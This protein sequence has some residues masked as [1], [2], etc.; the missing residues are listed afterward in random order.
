[1]HPIFQALADKDA[2]RRGSK[3]HARASRA[4]SDSSALVLTASSSSS[5]LLRQQNDSKKG[6]EATRPKP[7]RIHAQ[8]HEQHRGRSESPATS[9]TGSNMQ[10]QHAS[11]D[12]L[13]AES[14]SLYA[15]RIQQQQQYVGHRQQQQQQHKQQHRYTSLMN[16][17]VYEHPSRSH[18][19]GGGGGKSK[20]SASQEED[21]TE[22]ERAN[23]SRTQSMSSGNKSAIKPSKKK[24][25]APKKPHPQQTNL[26]QQ[27][28]QKQNARDS[29]LVRHLGRMSPEEQVDKFLQSVEEVNAENDIRGAVKV[30][31]SG[32]GGGTAKEAPEGGRDRMFSKN[33]KMR[34]G[35][36]GIG[37][38]V[39]IGVAD[40]GGGGNQRW[41]S[42]D[43]LTYTAAA[44]SKEVAD[45]PTKKKSSL[46]H[47]LP[48][49][50]KPSLRQKQKKISS[51]SATVG[52]SG[53]EI[54]GPKSFASLSELDRLGLSGGQRES[55]SMEFEGGGGKG[56]AGRKR[57]QRGIA[58]G[59][60][61]EE[62]R[63]LSMSSMDLSRPEQQHHQNKHHHNHGSSKQ[64][65]QQQQQQIPPSPISTSSTSSVRTNVIYLGRVA[66][67]SGASNLASLQLPLKNLYLDFIRLSKSGRSPPPSSLEIGEEG[68]RVSYAEERLRGVQEI[69]NP[70]PTIAVWAAV[71]FI[72]RREVVSSEQ[73]EGADGGGGNRNRFL[74]AFLP[75]ISD[76][77]DAEKDQVVLIISETRS[78][79]NYVSHCSFSIHCPRATSSSPPPLSIPPSSPAS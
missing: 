35:G 46:H 7:F 43:N 67:S 41:R 15:R 10:Q 38:G 11:M 22:Q 63:K 2:K 56:A 54:N 58:G 13:V 71:R 19:G 49:F 18:S 34:G 61:S 14:N 4:E 28:M 47:Q 25:P 50:N 1:M 44:E 21:T 51:S 76:P 69:F 27:P 5:S 32:G 74:F 73:G 8:V 72:Y 42:M 62:E 39:E 33:K 52:F 55:S 77:G 30:R 59:K 29:G 53:R 24:A 20:R 66:L 68:L 79:F 3:H 64:Q 23:S 78:Q 48:P 36:V 12:N 6:R 9:A 75:L 57:K 45:S 37:I 70:F 26:E 31:R 40:G 16:L 60:S 17:S 65:Q